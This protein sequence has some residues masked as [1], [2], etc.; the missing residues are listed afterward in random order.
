MSLGRGKEWREW[1]FE[2]WMIP[3]VKYTYIYI[4]IK[5]VVGS[6]TVDICLKTSG[7]EN[8]SGPYPDPNLAS[9]L[10]ICNIYASS[11][12]FALVYASPT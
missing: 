8:G 12:L 3:K 6:V 5:V 11:S 9:L 1:P 2:R 7:N 4:Y 10:H